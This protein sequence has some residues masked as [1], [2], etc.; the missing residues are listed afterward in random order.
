MA[1][2]LYVGNLEKTVTEEEL[3]ALFGEQGDILSV[4]IIKDRISG[5]SRGF[6][7]VEFANRDDAEK[8]KNA[9]NGQELKGLALKVDEAK[10]REQRE[11]RPSRGDSSRGSGGRRPRY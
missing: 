4:A 3:E 10:E 11:R 2:K 5:E 1:A 8:A 9:L 6:G 7:F